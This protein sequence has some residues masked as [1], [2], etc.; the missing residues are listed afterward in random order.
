MK[1]VIATGLFPPDVGGPAQYA[2]HLFDE[3]EKQGHRVKV[4]SYAHEHSLP[5]GIRHVFYLIRL[6]SVLRG[7]DVIFA[8]DT[9]SVG[10][11]AVIAGFFSGKP[12]RSPHAPG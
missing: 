6:F 2:K 5:Q 10:L 4:L 9:F 3:F 7:V 12:Q 1:I 11:P 8:L